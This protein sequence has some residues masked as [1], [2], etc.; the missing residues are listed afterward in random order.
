MFKK[1]T[2]VFFGLA[3]GLA[4]I[5]SQ[6][7]V[8][9]GQE[10]CPKKYAAAKALLNTW[11]KIYFLKPGNDYKELDSALAIIDGNLARCPEYKTRMTSLKIDLL[12]LRKD[13]E[14]AFKFIETLDPEGFD[15]PYRKKYY[16]N[17]LK[18]NMLD[19]KGDTLGRDAHYW[20]SVDEL[21]AFLKLKENASDVMAIS[22][23]FYLKVKLEKKGKVLKDLDAILAKYPGST[24]DKMLL[25]GL[26][27]NILNGDSSAATV[28]IE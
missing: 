22:D 21:E 11:R 10:D 5:A 4:G 15:R 25:Y 12:L 3:A 19:Q 8:S 20:K 27:S 17:A 24:D 14:K 13:D 6:G 18:A 7:C 28:V 16:L 23:L 1:R 26:R 9:H 2:I